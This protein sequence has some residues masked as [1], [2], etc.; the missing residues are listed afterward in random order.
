MDAAEFFALLVRM[1]QGDE[2]AEK[3]LREHGCMSVVNAIL[4]I[5]KLTDIRIEPGSF[6]MGMAYES[7]SGVDFFVSPEN[8]E[9][10]TGAVEMAR[11][12]YATKAE[13]I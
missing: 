8:K 7:H 2:D 10:I 11:E 5:E 6:L 13:G 1:T 9:H 3:T 12:I 4:A